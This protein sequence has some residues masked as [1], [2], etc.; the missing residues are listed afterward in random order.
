MFINVEDALRQVVADKAQLGLAPVSKLVKAIEQFPY[1]AELHFLYGSELAE[2]GNV[3]DAIASLGQA[4]ILKPDLDVARFQLAFLHLVNGNLDAATVLFQ[5]LVHHD[6]D[7]KNYLTFFARGCIA[8]TLDKLDE[9]KQL[10]EQGMLLNSSNEAL[11]KNMSNML[12]L[13]FDNDAEQNNV[14]GTSDNASSVL[15]DIYTQQKH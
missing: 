7:N 4:L 6:G 1:A 14:G 8:L 3:L 12:A 15:F 10:I 5:P 13:L 2:T 9:C 11:N